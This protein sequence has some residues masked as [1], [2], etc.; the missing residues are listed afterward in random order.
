[1]TAKSVLLCPQGLRLRAST[2]IICTEWHAYC[3]SYSLLKDGFGLEENIE[4]MQ[5]FFLT[6][7]K[8]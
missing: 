4:K 8:K 2:I 6:Q 1:M 3:R 7:C 5:K